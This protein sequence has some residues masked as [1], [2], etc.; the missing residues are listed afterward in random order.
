MPDNLVYLEDFAPQSNQPI[1]DWTP[2]LAAAKNSFSHQLDFNGQSPAGTILASH[3]P[4][5][6]SIAAL[7]NGVYKFGSQIVIDR[8]VRIVGSGA[9]MLNSAGPTQ[10]AFGA[11]SGGVRFDYS[12]VDSTGATLENL[13]LI[14]WGN[15]SQTQGHGIEATSA[16]VARNLVIRGFGR[17]GIHIVSDASGATPASASCFRLDNVSVMGC[18]GD[19]LYT[20]GGD[21]NIGVIENCTFRSNNGW[22]INEQSFL[23]NTYV[24]VHI[25]SNKLGGVNA[26][27]PGGCNA[28]LGCYSENDQLHRIDNPSVVVGGLLAEACLAGRNTGTARVY[29]SRA[30][31]LALRAVKM[32]GHFDNGSYVTPVLANG[33][34]GLGNAYGATLPEVLLGLKDYQE[35]GGAWPFRL[36]WNPKGGFGMDWAGTGQPIL[37][38]INRRN[39][40]A[41][42]FPF[43]VSLADTPDIYNNG[44]IG[45]RTLTL[46]SLQSGMI[47]DDVGKAIPTDNRPLGSRRFNNSGVEGESEYWLK[48]RAG[49]KAKGS[50]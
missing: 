40:K 27:K 45:L 39:T 42:G 43:D 18:N 20:A 28:F 4:G 22:G 7:T 25:A 21:S 2:I 38:F 49:W 26:P 30:A 33:E 10:F 48:T 24:G 46:G 5:Q 6:A 11:N 14:G 19:G 47:V 17:N 34:I 12:P 36:S 13:S 29:G 23:G 16:F 3:R 50:I 9:P 8:A 44:G 31:A 35:L 41:N 32:P 1:Y 37:W 15:I